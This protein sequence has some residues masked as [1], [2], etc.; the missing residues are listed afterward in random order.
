MVVYLDVVFLTNFALDFAMLLAAAKVRSVKPALW[1]VGLSSA[2]GASYVLMMFVPAMTVFYSFVV[3][4]LFSAMMIMTAFGY[5]S[6][7]RFAGLL[8]AFYVVNAAAAGTIVGVHYMLQSSHDVWNG[9]LFT[10]TGGFQYA[11]GVSLWSVVAAG[12]VGVMAFRRVNAGAKRKEKKAEFLAEVVVNVGEASY[13][14]TG[15]ID[16][17]N[18]LYDPLT[19]T[20][21]MVMEAA[22]WKDAIPERWLEAIRARE[23]DRVLQWLGETAA[24]AEAGAEETFP[25]RERLRLVPYRGINGNTTFMLAMKP[26]GVTIVRDGQQTDVTKVLI[27]IDGGTLSAD[28]AYQAI[29]HPAMVP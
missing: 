27:G 8:A 7:A 24:G 4:C 1:R 11:L 9:I 29:I 13:R 14:C 26:D 12:A 23:A 21:V 28:G 18:H 20:P 16:T 5:K 2:I 17:G 19:R 6:F 15:L 25:W 10:S 3:K 22:V